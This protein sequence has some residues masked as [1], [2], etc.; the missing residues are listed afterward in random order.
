M[1]IWS[2]CTGV[3]HM[4]KGTHFSFRAA[5]DE[6]CDEVTYSAKTVHFDTYIKTEFNIS[7]CLD[8]LS[9]A[10]VLQKFTSLIIS[11]KEYQYSQIE[12]NIRF[13]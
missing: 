5:I 10:E 12:A 1:S 13:T 9:A 7:L 3:V 6:L 4:R 11:Q 8:G 2:T